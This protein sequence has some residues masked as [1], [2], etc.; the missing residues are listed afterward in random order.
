MFHA[1][2]VPAV[3][4]VA[5]PGEDRDSLPQQERACRDACEARGWA[6]VR[7]PTPSVSPTQ[8]GTIA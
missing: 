2:I 8:G 4:T 7:Q 6:M 3:S 1:L 5:Q